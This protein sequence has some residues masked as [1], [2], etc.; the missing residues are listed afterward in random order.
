MPPRKKSE[1]RKDGALVVVP[2]E[3]TSDDRVNQAYWLRAQQHASWEDIA[4]ALGYASAES[5]RVSVRQY[6]ERAAAELG[7]KRRRAALE[8]ELGL[9]DLY[10]TV[11]MPRILDGD[12]KA[13]ELMLKA[14]LNR[15]KLSGLL[16]TDREQSGVRTIVVSAERFAEQM[17]E[18]ALEGQGA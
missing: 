8:H 3:M 18:I 16:D 14:G 17:K 10:E 12:L 11:L 7:D 6:L 15:A 1:A 5:A 2:D 9:L 4:Q 13:M